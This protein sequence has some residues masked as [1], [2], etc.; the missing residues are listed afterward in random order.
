[1]GA[2]KRFSLHLSKPQESGAAT[3]DAGCDVRDDDARRGEAAWDGVCEFRWVQR[4]CDLRIKALLDEW[5][6]E[7]SCGRELLPWA[8]LSSRA[9][10]RLDS[11]TALEN[12]DLALPHRKID[13]LSTGEWYAPGPGPGSTHGDGLRERLG[14]SLIFFLGT[15]DAL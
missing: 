7:D 10:G 2:H 12:V 15:D 14:L 1:V 4:S 6:Q 8:L 9:T 5:T 3:G 11:R 13:E